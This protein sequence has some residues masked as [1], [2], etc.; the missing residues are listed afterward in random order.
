MS[1]QE[2]TNAEEQTEEQKV[3]VA[4]GITIELLTDGSIRVT[5][6]ESSPRDVNVHDVEYLVLRADREGLVQKV[7]AAVTSRQLQIA[8]Q[9]R[10]LSVLQQ[11]GIPKKGL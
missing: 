3:G 11:V 6:A 1:E 9:M 4:F 2:K 8:Q 5:K 7:S 10:A